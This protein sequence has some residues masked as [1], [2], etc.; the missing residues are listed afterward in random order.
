MNVEIG[1]IFVF[2]VWCAARAT[3]TAEQAKKE[4]SYWPE[5]DLTKVTSFAA[6]ARTHAVAIEDCGPRGRNDALGHLGM[7]IHWTVRT[8]GELYW[9]CSKA[10]GPSEHRRETYAKRKKEELA[11]IRDM[12][13]DVWPKVDMVEKATD[14]TRMKPC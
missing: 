10:E 9:C 3:R 12:A 13:R 14:V 7:T 2:A 4:R 6:F 8:V 5:A 11:A 1:R